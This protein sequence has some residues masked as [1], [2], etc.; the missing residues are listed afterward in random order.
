MRKVIILFVFYLATVNIS[1]AQLQGQEKINS[2]LKELPKLKEDTNGVYLYANLSFEYYLINPEEGIK[3]G[4]KGLELAEKIAWKE[5]KAI[6]YSALGV[7]YEGGISDFSKAI[8]FYY[9]SLRINEELGNKPG[10]AINHGN[11]GSIYF[12]LSNFTK[13]LEYYHK[14]LKYL[15]ELGNKRGIGATLGNI[16]IVYAEQT[17]YSKALEHY[18]KALKINEELNNKN[19]IAINLGHIGNVYAKQSHYPKGIEYYS[20]ALKINKELGN[21]SGIATNMANFGIIYLTQAQ[22]SVIEVSENKIELLLNKE[23]NIDKAIEY[24]QKSI[25]IYKELGELHNQS[26]IFKNLSDAYFVK[27]DFKKAFEAF[28]EYKTLQDSVFSMDKQKEFANLEAKRENEL[29]DAE[30]IILQTEKKAQQFQSYLLAG[31]VI[32]LFSAFGIAFFRFREKKKLSEKLAIQKSEIENQKLLVEEKNEQIYASIRYAS[33]IQ[34]A[35]LPWDAILGKAFSDFMIFFKPKDI[36]SGDSYWFKEVDGVKFLAVIDCTGHGIPGSMLTVIASSV[37]D[38]A[39][40]GKRLK[41]TGE[42]LTYMNDKVTEVLNQRLKENEVRD[43]MEVALIAINAH[44]VQFSGA[45]RPLYMK[46][47]TSFEIMKTDRRGIAGRAEDDNYVYTSLE[48]TILC[49]T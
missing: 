15:E 46:N 41:N 36:V 12:R 29:K 11:I 40:L 3:Y 25:D 27:G 32:V 43:G 45:G 1:F 48:V 10:I 37:L 34:N 19:G 17:K 31:G 39:V 49:F 5:G 4:E 9:K 20:K 28:K 18:F 13:A 33:T 21:K 35:I 16:G 24:S 7:N 2:L 42:I 14:S 22:D 8:E 47:N 23:I 26:S 38:D 30:I 6:C 44:K